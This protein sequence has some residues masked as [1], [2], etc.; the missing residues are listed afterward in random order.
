MGGIGSGREAD[1]Y[2]GIVEESLHLDVN[3]LVKDGAIKSHIQAN[4]MLKWNRP[5]GGKSSIGYEIQTFVQNGHICLIYIVSR[6][7]MGEKAINY[8]VELYTT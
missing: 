1:V 3:K 7:G 6:L 5:I 2:S 4:G 8:N